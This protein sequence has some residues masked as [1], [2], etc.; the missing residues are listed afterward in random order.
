MTINRALPRVA[1]AAAAAVVLLSSCTE[2][3]PTVSTSPTSTTSPS[4]TASP[5]A[6]STLSPAKRQALDEATEAV[7]AY[8][9]TF[10][11]ILADPSPRLNDMNDVAAQPQLDIDLRNLEA[12]VN[13]GQTTIDS[14]GPV[15]VASAAPL[16][17]DL[18]GDPA[19]VTALVC[20]DRTA[21]TGT[22]K[23]EPTTGLRQQAQ[24]VVV[25][26]TYLPAPGWAVSRVSPPKGHDQPQPC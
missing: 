25:K 21:V 23:G 22:V 7:R 20:V 2:P 14:T 4:A 26:T 17:I 6:T 24:Y 11:D 5:S 18:K 15:V 19:S 3:G 8:E 16:T 9:Q 13:G 12:I 10:I 1:I